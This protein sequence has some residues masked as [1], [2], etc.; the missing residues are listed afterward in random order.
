MI[1]VQYPSLADLKNFQK[2][3]P[4]FINVGVKVDNIVR[5][6]FLVSVT[7]PPPPPSKMKCYH[8]DGREWRWDFKSNTLRLDNGTTVIISSSILNDGSFTLGTKS[9]PIVIEKLN[10]KFSLAQNPDFSSSSFLL[11]NKSGN[12]FIYNPESDYYIGHDNNTDQLMA[13]HYFDDRIIAWKCSEYILSDTATSSESTFTTNSYEFVL[14]V[15]TIKIQGSGFGT[16]YNNSVNFVV[17]ELMLGN[18]K[19]LSH[20]RTVSNWT[21]TTVIIN[22]PQLTD[23]KYFYRYNPTSVNIVLY[24]VGNVFNLLQPVRVPVF[25]SLP[26]QCS[27]PDGFKWSAYGNLI[28]M[29]DYGGF[30]MTLSLYEDNNTYGSSRGMYNLK[31]GDNYLY[32]QVNRVVLQPITYPSFQYSFLVIKTGRGFL[33]YVDFYDPVDYYVSVHDNGNLVVS[34]LASDG[35]VYWDCNIQELPVAGNH[36]NF[37]TDGVYTT[38]IDPVLST[39]FIKPLPQILEIQWVELARSVLDCLII[40]F[41]LSKMPLR[42]HLRE[43]MGLTSVSSNS[44]GNGG[45]F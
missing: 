9:G 42:R 32:N 7:Y 28:T 43:K 20:K 3:K 44:N 25:S 14:D 39:V 37:N 18:E 6:Q 29:T 36:T 41:V 23:L 24:A 4:S 21:D 8:P 31:F 27:Y 5:D 10:R 17:F 2:Y 19:L 15:N 33:F 11:T 35:L 30:P 40:G 13:V 16:Y 34:D 45:A 26:F 12:V 22:Y 1:D 38:K